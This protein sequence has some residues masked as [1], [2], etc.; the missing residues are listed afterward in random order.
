MNWKKEIKY[1]VICGGLIAWIC[2][3]DAL[4]TAIENGFGYLVNS[5]IK[6]I[7]FLILLLSLIGIVCWRIISIF[8]RAKEIIYNRIYEK[9]R[10]KGFEEGF[11]EAYHG[12]K[13]LY[14]NVVTCC[15]NFIEALSQHNLNELGDCL[16]YKFSEQP[17]SWREFIEQATDQYID[18]LS[19]DAKKNWQELAKTTA[20]KYIDATNAVRRGDKGSP[21]LLSNFNIYAECVS[22]ILATLTS[23]DFGKHVR[24]WTLL[25][26]P[27]NFWYNM[28]AITNDETKSSFHCT[29]EWWEEYKKRVSDLKDSEKIQMRRIIVDQKTDDGKYLEDLYLYK[30]NGYVRPLSI[31]D[32]ISRSLGSNAIRPIA[33]VE[34][35]LNPVNEEYL[36]EKLYIIGYPINAK[37]K[38]VKPSVN[39]PNQWVR[40][41]THF[42]EEYH[43]GF[44][45]RLKDEKG[46]YYCFVKER[47]IEGNRDLSA[48]LLFD[49]IF[50]VEFSEHDNYIDGFGIAL[51][52]DEKYDMVGITLLSG[53]VLNMTRKA[54]KTK[55]ETGVSSAI[56]LRS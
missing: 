39:I 20:C 45:K 48:Y 52:I 31:R 13:E 46:V 10:A 47:D 38:T 50:L 37:N 26:K 54:L 34:M 12:N 11:L 33:D 15:K 41:S 4:W 19:G 23:N 9:G 25:N 28:L 30:E 17:E 44:K 21:I 24:V 8:V 18:N 40:L 16:V 7:F 51:N 29:T 22:S 6:R 36:N 32:A 56:S 27:L 14:G 35:A 1:I 55:W 43:R 2:T 49:D 42:H 53:R 5:E 3:L